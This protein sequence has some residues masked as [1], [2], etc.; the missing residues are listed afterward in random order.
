MSGFARTRPQRA[1]PEPEGRPDSTVPLASFACQPFPVCLLAR[2][3]NRAEAAAE[4]AARRLV[5][6]SGRYTLEPG[7]GDGIF[8]VSNLT[9]LCFGEEGEQGIPGSRRQSASS[10]PRFD[11]SGGQADRFAG[12]RASR[13]RGR[14]AGRQ[15]AHAQ[16]EQRRNDEPD[17][18]TALEPPMES[19]LQPRRD[20][21]PSR[22]SS[23]SRG[24]ASSPPLAFRRRT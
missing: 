20:M 10:W 8:E 22:L 1:E 18:G 9:V 11:R 12:A 17:P 4:P 23:R 2:R 24:G 7:A 6:A 21:P 19:C 13:E 14:R 16:D 3:A 5:D 15:Q